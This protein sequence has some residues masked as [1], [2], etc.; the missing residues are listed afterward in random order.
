MKVRNSEEIIKKQVD[1]RAII[2]EM[3]RQTKMVK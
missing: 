1:R 3:N 2:G